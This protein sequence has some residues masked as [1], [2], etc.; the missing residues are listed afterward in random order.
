MTCEEIVG[1]YISQLQGEFACLPTPDNRIRLITPYL[2]P[3]HDRIELFIRFHEDDV[4]VSDLGETLRYL[5][6]TGMQIIG[7]PKR[8]FKANRIA[9]G[10]GV[11]MERGVILKRGKIAAIG[12]M[13]FDVI[14]ACKAVGDLVYS[15]NAYEP[16][17]FEEEVI[18]FLATE[19]IQ[20]EPHVPVKGQSNTDY[21]VSI[22]VF[23][24]Q[25][26]IL[27][28]TVSPKTP[29]GLTSRVDRIFRM[30][31]DVNGNREKIT[32]F[33]DDVALVRPEDVYVLEHA[34]SYVHRWTARELFVAALKGAE[35]VH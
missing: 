15:G 12:E 18:D 13:V 10:L 16:A 8:Q 1:N 31:N 35:R 28:A 3:D 21:K 2:Y 32:L 7:F 9:D 30:W 22:R 19:K 11:Q 5:D 26:E 27:I 4:I 17:V 25:R 34:N 29:A 14:T 20:C 24:A 6:T 23:M 33:N